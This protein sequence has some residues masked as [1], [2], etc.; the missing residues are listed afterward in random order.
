MPLEK[1]TIKT[2]FIID[3]IL[4]QCDSGQDLPLTARQ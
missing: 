1:T 4:P 2:L 3:P